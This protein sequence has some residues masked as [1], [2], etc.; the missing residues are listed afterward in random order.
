[1]MDL[2]FSS[3]GSMCVDISVMDD[4]DLEMDETFNLMLSTEDTSVTLGN[5]M[6]VITIQDGD[7]EWC[8]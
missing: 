5:S 1:M 3:A 4:G 6:T 7:G 2:T 8:D